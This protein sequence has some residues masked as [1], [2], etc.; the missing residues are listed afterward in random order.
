[1]VVNVEGCS[2]GSKF[3]LW[4]LQLKVSSTWAKKEGQFEIS[5]T[6]NLYCTDYVGQWSDFL[7][8]Y[9]GETILLRK[10]FKGV[11]ITL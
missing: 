5:H 1:M 2:L 6:S 10:T 9:D 7:Y 4:H 8:K 3:A 11:L